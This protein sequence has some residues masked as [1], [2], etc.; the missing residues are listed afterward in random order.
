MTRYEILDIVVIFVI[1]IFGSFFV[2]RKFKK[3]QLQRERECVQG[4][5][6]DPFLDHVRAMRNMP[7]VSS[8]DILVTDEDGK[9]YLYP[10]GSETRVPQSMRFVPIPPHSEWPG[11]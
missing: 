3:L 4:E 7:G 5:A 8:G 2:S 11:S 6:P 1:A 9:E 10:E